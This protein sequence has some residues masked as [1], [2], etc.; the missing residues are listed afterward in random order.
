MPISTPFQRIPLKYTGLYSD[1]HIIDLQEFGVSLQG[2][3]KLANSVFNFYLSGE[4]ARNSRLYQVRLFVA[5]PEP[6]CVLLDILAIIAAG[7]LPLYMPLICDLSSNYVIPLIKSIVL[8]RLGKKDAMEKMV[9]KI[10]EMA[11]DHNEFAREVHNGHMRDKSWLQ[12]HIE[13]LTQL[14]IPALR[15]SVDPIGKSCKEIAL[16][17][18]SPV[19]TLIG[20]AEAKVLTTREQLNVDDSREYVGIFE[21]VDTINGNCKFAQ[22]GSDKAML[23]RITDPALLMPQNPYTHSL[24]TKGPVKIHAKAVSKDGVAVKLFISDA[25][26]F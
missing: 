20:E 18:P 15:Q 5:P 3:A 14:N 6:G 16:G 10:V 12:A 4:V 9:E 17:P 24:D 22:V 2:W 11:H 1:D 26:S 23:G 21:A 13:T 19:Q 7:Q 25:E 8:N